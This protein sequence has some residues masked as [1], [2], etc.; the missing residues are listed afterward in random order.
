QPDNTGHPWPNLENGSTFTYVPESFLHSECSTSWVDANHPGGYIA[1]HLAE[2]W[3]EPF[4]S[5]RINKCDNYIPSLTA[6][7]GNQ[8]CKSSPS[9]GIIYQRYV[10][11]STSTDNN[12]QHGCEA[13]VYA[14]GYPYD[15]SENYNKWFRNG[16]L[17]F[18]E[19]LN[20]GAYPVVHAPDDHTWWDS[21]CSNAFT[22]KTNWVYS[23]N[24]QF[25]YISYEDRGDSTP[26]PGDLNGDTIVNRQD[27]DILVANFGNPYTIFDY[28]VLV[29]NFGKGV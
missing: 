23:G 1:L 25:D 4:T 22:Q 14:W 29:G 5:L 12:Y 28:N 26:I 27:Y 11:G 20:M 3:S 9:V 13:T 18:S 24:H 21:G 7:N 10:T 16:E 8:I 2:T 19:W 17:R 15:S 6:P